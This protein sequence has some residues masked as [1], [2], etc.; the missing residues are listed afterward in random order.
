VS[1]AFGC[2]ACSAGKYSNKEGM[3]KETACKECL[4]GHHQSDSRRL[5]SMR[6]GV[7]PR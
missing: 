5:R 7:L 4:Q 1:S 6:T 2:N 3:R